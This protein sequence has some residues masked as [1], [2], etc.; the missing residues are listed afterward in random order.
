MISIG[1]STSKKAIEWLDTWEPYF[2]AHRD[3]PVHDERFIGYGFDRK[4][5]ICELHI[6]GYEFN[7]LSNDFLV[8]QGKITKLKR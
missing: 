8:H 1:K 6:A 3:S 4:S 2:I 7:L 5:Q